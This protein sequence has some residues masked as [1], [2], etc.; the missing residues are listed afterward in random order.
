M[1]KSRRPGQDGGLTIGQ[2]T[3]H[4]DETRSLFFQLKKSTQCLLEMMSDAP[5]NAGNHV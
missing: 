2:L 5:T 4:V 3:I 1:H